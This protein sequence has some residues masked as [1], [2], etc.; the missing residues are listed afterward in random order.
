MVEVQCYLY[1]KYLIE[2]ELFALHLHVTC[3]VCADFHRNI[4]VLFTVLD[5]E[6]FFIVRTHRK[7]KKR[8][9][10]NLRALVL[11]ALP[12]NSGVTKNVQF[13]KLGVLCTT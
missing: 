13:G 8:L 7:R 12:S 3:D 6:D 9:A 4:L 1:I 10:V 11:F 5:L 2:S